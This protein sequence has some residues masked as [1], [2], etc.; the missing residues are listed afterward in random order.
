VPDLAHVALDLLIDGEAGIWHLTSP[1]EVSWRNLA[2]NVAER[3]GLDPRLVLAADENGPRR[4]TAL[5]SER[6]VLLP[7]LDSA[8]GRYFLE[9]QA[10]WSASGRIM[11]A[12]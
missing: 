10:D 5:T 12:E 9:C 1:G 4:N 3:A 8:L 6:G 11:A 7:P 2:V